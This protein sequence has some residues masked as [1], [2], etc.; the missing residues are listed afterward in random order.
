MQ[1][2]LN[3][4]IAASGKVYHCYCREGGAALELEQRC[5]DIGCEYVPLRLT[6]ADDDLDHQRF[7]HFRL[8]L[9]LDLKRG[10][11]AGFMT[12]PPM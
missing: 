11:V 4:S 6:G 8:R 2:T 1:Y 10:V 7:A 12:D 9:L 3:A 5:K